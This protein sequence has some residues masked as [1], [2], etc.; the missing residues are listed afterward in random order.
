M[1]CTQ[2]PLIVLQLFFVTANDSNKLT[3]PEG[4][5]TERYYY[6]IKRCKDNVEDTV[7]IGDKDVGDLNLLLVYPLITEGTE[8]GES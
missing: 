1:N 7:I 8:N 2:R 3:V 5:K 4:K 6:G